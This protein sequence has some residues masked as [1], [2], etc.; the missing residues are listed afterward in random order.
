MDLEA[1]P[2][3][4]EAERQVLTLVLARAGVSLDEAPGPYAG[5][6]KRAATREGIDNEPARVPVRGSYALSPRSTRGATR[7]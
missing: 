1:F 4:S 3:L 7:A 2:P 5:A 6:W